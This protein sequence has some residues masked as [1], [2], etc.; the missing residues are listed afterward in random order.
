MKRMLKTASLLSAAALAPML[1]ASTAFAGNSTDVEAKL[2]GYVGQDAR[3]AISANALQQL[4]SP[5]VSRA[6]KSTTERVLFWHDALLDSI[7]IDLTFDPG[8]GF[9]PADQVGPTRASR[10]MAISQIAVFDAL[11]AFNGTDKSSSRIAPA[12]TGASQEGAIA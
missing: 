4:S 7:G 12:Q 9:T 8:L 2:Y 1:I 3:S 10:A 5:S 11:N 6:T